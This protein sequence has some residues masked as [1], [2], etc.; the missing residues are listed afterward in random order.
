MALR[1]V[2]FDVYGHCWSSENFNLEPKSF[3]NSTGFANCPPDSKKR[4]VETYPNSNILFEPPVPFQSRFV[5][6]LDIDLSNRG[7]SLEEKAKIKYYNLASHLFSMHSALSAYSVSKQDKGY[8]FIVLSRFDTVIT[9]F[10][11]LSKLDPECLH[12]SDVHPRFPD[13][14]FIGSPNNIMALDIWPVFARD[15]LA[16]QAE[17]LIAEKLKQSEYLKAYPSSSIRQVSL[18]AVPLRSRGR[19]SS[20]LRLAVTD[21]AHSMFRQ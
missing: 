16:F 1:N 2:E 19:L 14:I 15:P 10:P 18:R 8:D 7:I 5:K 9:K 21:L 4:V 11:N 13:M 3:S 20:L 12:V 17:S 6:E